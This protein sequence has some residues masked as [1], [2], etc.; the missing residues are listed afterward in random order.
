MKLWSRILL[1]K[2]RERNTEIKSALIEEART[3]AEIINWKEGTEKVNDLKARWIKTGNAE[4]AK[5]EELEQQ[6]WSIVENFFEQKKNF[7][8]D[9]QKL[10]DLRRKQYENLVLEAEKTSELYGRDKTQKIKELRETWKGV[11]G[12]PNDVFKPLVEKFNAHLRPTYDKKQSDYTEILKSL[13]DIK[14]RK[15]CL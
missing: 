4:E 14:K 5:N 8:E 7:Y 12:V 2:N 10:M 3:I 1:R 6:F 15:F 11:G 9:K 13:E